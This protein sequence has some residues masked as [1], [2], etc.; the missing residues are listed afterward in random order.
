MVSPLIPLEAGRGVRR[1]SVLHSVMRAFAASALFATLLSVAAP[2]I[3][4]AADLTIGSPAP[5]LAVKT[6][7]KGTPVKELDPAKTYV[8]EFW[9]TWCG[10]CIQSIPHVT[11][12]AKANPDVTFMGVGIWEDQKGDNLD[13]F[14]AKMG[15]KMGYN[16]GYSG[17]KDGMAATWMDAAGRNGIPCAFIVKEGKIAWVGHPMEMEEPLAQ[18]KAGTFD[19]ATFKAKFDKEAE[20]QEKAMAAQKEIR[21]VTKMYT[22]G[23][24]AGA[25]AA[26][27][28]YRKG[29]PDMKADADSVAFGWMA[30][31]DPAAWEAQ[32]K[33]LA[34]S[35]DPMDKQRLLSFALSRSAAE[36]TRPMA[37]K[38]MGFAL[39]A[40]PK[41]FIALQYAR[42]V[43]KNTG[44]AKL[45]LSAVDTLLATLPTTPAKDDAD[46]K[47]GLEK[48]RAELQTKVAK[49]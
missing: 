19:T 40:A 10:P 5:P 9:A 45:A 30:M 48:D 11:K 38:A 22:D 18:I 20:E 27:A 47:A 8:V 32:A 23:D 26:L 43:Y 1:E 6:W 34:A 37:R 24:K 33:T 4:S 14:V 29:H 42:I 35:K 28:A 49:G 46:F 7:L 36:E 3:A 13:K 12:L 17:N 21:K 44:D 16:V 31:E 2:T 25:K 15:D 41:D 39:A